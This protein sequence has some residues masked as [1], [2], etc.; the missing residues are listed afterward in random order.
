M[1]VPGAVGVPEINPL[2]GSTLSPSGNPL[3]A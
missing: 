1:L 2:S 3:A